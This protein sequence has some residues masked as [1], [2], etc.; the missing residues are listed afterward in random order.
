LAPFLPSHPVID[1]L[2]SLGSSSKSFGVVS[3]APFGSSAILPISW[4]YIKVCFSEIEMKT[5]NKLIDTQKLDDGAERVEES[6]TGGY[7]ERKLHEQAAGGTLLWR[8]N[9]SST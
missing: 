5:I 6:N 1:P 3:A 2:A 8:T 9:S 4:A 7:F